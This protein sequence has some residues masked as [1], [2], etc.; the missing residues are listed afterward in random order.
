[1]V[2]KKLKFGAL[3][4]LNLPKRTHD[5]VHAPS[6]SLRLAVRHDIGDIEINKKCY[7]SFIDVCKR[8]KTLKTL[9]EWTVQELS[10][11]LLCQKKT[12]GVMLPE[13][14]LM[15]DDSLGF[16]ISVYG[17]LL[18]EDHDIYTTNLRS[19][20]NLTIS[21]L[22]KSLNSQHIGPGVEPDELSNKIVHHLIPK[23]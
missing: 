23:G 4:T 16:T 7:S 18:P 11:R 8:V 21:D 19:V 2:K 3:P 17:W 22:I 1:M 15:I 13:V 5:T 14:E 9:Q 10:D 20:C 6:R 12:A